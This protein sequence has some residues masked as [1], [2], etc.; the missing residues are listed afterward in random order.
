MLTEHVRLA[1]FD[2]NRVTTAGDTDSRGLRRLAHR[3]ETAL[4]TVIGLRHKADR[5]E[6]TGNFVTAT[7]A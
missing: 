6:G 1:G 4:L 2:G 3:V 5:G 7:A